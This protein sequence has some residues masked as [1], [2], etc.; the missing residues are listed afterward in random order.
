MSDWGIFVI[1]KSASMTKNREQ[2]ITGYNDLIGSIKQNCSRI[3][4]ILFNDI[5]DIFD[6][7]IKQVKYMNNSDYV[8]RGHTALYDAIGTAYYL[9][10]S[11]V[12]NYKKIVTNELITI[13]VY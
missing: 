5:I 4:L 3:T 10:I 6:K 2:V 12:I 1:D 9:I 11:N 8:P 7:D 13:K